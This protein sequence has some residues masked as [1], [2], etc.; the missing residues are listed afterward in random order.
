M[1]KIVKDTIHANGID[2]GIYTTDFENEFISLTDIAKYKSDDL[3]DNCGYFDG[4]IMQNG[5][6]EMP[7]TKNSC[8]KSIHH[9]GAFLFNFNLLTSFTDL[10]EATFITLPNYPLDSP[11]RF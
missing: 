2:I 1:T 9:A 11:F 6:S 5:L 8:M 10:S 4:A 7:I 3:I